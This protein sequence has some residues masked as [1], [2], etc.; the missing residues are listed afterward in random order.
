MKIK[1]K[2]SEE[3]KT[4]GVYMYCVGK[5]ESS[6]VPI[7]YFYYSEKDQDQRWQDCLKYAKYIEDQIEYRQKDV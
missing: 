5:E 2:H 7:K 4:Y 3:S 1:V 6:I